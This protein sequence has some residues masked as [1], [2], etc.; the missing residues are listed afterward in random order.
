MV[1]ED[2]RIE[3][4]QQVDVG[5]AQVG[6]RHLFVDHAGREAAEPL[7]AEFLGQLRSDEAHRAHLAHQFAV[8][9]AGLVALQE[10]RGDAIGG[11]AARMVA[12]GDEVFVEIR[13]HHLSPG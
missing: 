9:H 13:V 6:A 7:A 11:K 3:R 2:L 4:G 10:A 1:R 12:E 8:E 5:Q